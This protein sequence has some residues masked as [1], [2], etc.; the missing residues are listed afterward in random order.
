MN[1]IEWIKKFFLKVLNKIEDHLATVV[2][3]GI[4][5]IL[6]TLRIF[7]W[8]WLCAPHSLQFSGWLWV[9]IFL[10]ISI[11]PAVSVFLIIRRRTRKR[12]QVLT[13]DT[14]IKNSLRQWFRQYDRKS[15]DPWAEATTDYQ[16]TVNFSDLDQKLSLSPSS[17]K[18][19]IEDVVKEFDGWR[20]K[21]KGDD[22][23]VIFHDAPIIN[24]HRQQFTADNDYDRI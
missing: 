23:I 12:R 3:G 1:K 14:D 18:R 7:F 4:I 5:L 2:A 15:K 11:I 24:R 13:D 16:L 8:K 17:T 10:G 6:S 22:T 20:T 19:H 21:N 9:L